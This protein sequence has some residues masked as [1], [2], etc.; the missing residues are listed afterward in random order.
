MILALPW[1]PV[2]MTPAWEPVNDRACAPRDSIAMAT[3]ALEIRSRRSGACRVRVAGN[4]ADLLCQIEQF[5]GGVTH[6]RH[7]HHDVIALLFG[8]DDALGDPADPL[9]IGHRGSAV[10]LHDERHC[11]YLSLQVCIIRIKVAHRGLS[12]RAFGGNVLSRCP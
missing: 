12:S 6:R 1:V 2:V 9:G 7:D 8:L 4:L 3:S 10:L 5:V 11:L